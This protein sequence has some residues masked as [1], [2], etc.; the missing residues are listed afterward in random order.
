MLIVLLIENA[1]LMRYLYT[2]PASNTPYYRVIVDIN[3]PI[4]QKIENNNSEENIVEDISNND[5]LNN[6]LENKLM[7]V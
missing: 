1:T 4:K 3:R 2:A 7:N 6:F 5:V